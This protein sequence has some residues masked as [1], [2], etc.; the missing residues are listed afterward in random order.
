SM[1]EQGFNRVWSVNNLP[2][3]KYYWSVQSVDNNFAGSP[4]AGIDS[5]EICRNT[6]VSLGP[7]TTLCDGVIYTL[8]GGLGLTAYNWSTGA[9]TQTIDVTQPGTY[10]VTVTSADGCH[11]IDTV[12]IDYYP[13]M[14]IDAGDDVTINLNYSA[15]LHATGGVSYQWSPSES[16]D[17]ARIADPVASPLQTTL[18][19]VTVT[20]ANNCSDV[21]SVTVTVILEPPINVPNFISPNGDRV[22]D[23]L[24]I[25]GI[26]S[27]PGNQMIVFNRWGDI[28]YEV[29]D[30]QDDWDGTVKNTRLNLWGEEIPEGVYFYK[31]LLNNGKPAITGYITVK[32]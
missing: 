6:N 25:D 21:D 4:F 12:V 9:T 22:N 17:N 14:S 7:D 20:D 26:R 28:V 30:Y 27:Y 15:Q 10:H 5:F 11:A 23:V 19:H 13:P 3:G 29:T 8:D 16:L 24:V 2:K 31:L 18:Y 1:G 32:K